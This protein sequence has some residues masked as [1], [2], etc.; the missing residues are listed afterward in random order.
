MIRR[1]LIGTFF[2]L[3]LSG[4]WDN[5][6]INH[7]ALPIA[8]G[9]SFHQG[10]Y[11][12]YL[13]I[14]K[15]SVNNEGIDVVTANG[16]SISAAVNKIS[17]NMESQV[18]LL[19]LKVIV[20]DEPFAKLGLEEIT[21]N[22]IRSRHVSPKTMFV[23][24]DEPLDRF[25]T[26][27]NNETDGDGKEIY[28]FFQKDA[29]WNPEIAHTPVWKVF[30]SIHSYTNDVVVP[31]V[32]S[33]ESTTIESMGS[34]ILK[35]G[36]M[37]SRLNNE[38]TLFYNVFDG[39]SLEGKI[40]IMGHSTVQIVSSSI[41]N[42]GRFENNKPVLDSVLKL[43]V[44]ILDTSGQTSI[45]DFQTKLK[46]LLDHEMDQIFQKMKRANADIFGIGQHFRN[47]LP[48][49]ELAQWRSKYLPD[50]RINLDIK[51][52]VRNTGNLKLND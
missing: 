35:N 45:K 8:M 34:A 1:I 42:N 50:A 38:Q 23:I 2:L 21:S 30:R 26:R 51:T 52:T 13:D 49:T 20:V 33:G 22:I 44:T 17:V 10:E 9:I 46:K 31:I 16:D 37:V 32:K 39:K 4:C 12:V 40:E 11:K 5:K 36:R 29:G 24:S 3:M 28:D 43:N 14:P 25:F 27:I 7:R 48:R 6:D 15:V 18:D 47:E 41:K 19:H